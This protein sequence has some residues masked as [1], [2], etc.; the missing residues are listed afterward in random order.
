V[1]L[2]LQWLLMVTQSHR[3]KLKLVTE[4]EEAAVCE[5]DD[6]ITG[7]AL[8]M[9]LRAAPRLN[10][11]SCFDLRSSGLSKCRCVKLQEVAV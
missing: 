8:V 11:R 6:V 10:L 3:Y 9:L 5:V 1:L 2:E 4:L 7:A